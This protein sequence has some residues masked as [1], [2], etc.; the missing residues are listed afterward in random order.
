MN[1][2]NNARS[3]QELVGLIADDPL[4]SSID[5]SYLDELQGQLSWVA[6]AEGET[7]FHEGDAVDGFYFVISGLLE[8][9]KMQED[10]DGNPDNDRLVLAEI[11][12]DSTIGEMQILTGGTRSATVSAA[13][14]SGLVKFPKH[15]F[16][17]FLAKNQNVVDALAKTIMPRLYRDQ[18]VDVLPKL[19]G[20]LDDETLHDL[21]AKMTWRS[22]RRGDVLCYQGEPSESFYVIISGRMQVLIKDASGK[23]RVVTEMSQG[24]SVGEMGVVTGQ[25]RSATIIASRDTELLEFSREEFEEFTQRYP[26]LMRRMTRLLI[27]RLQR[28]SRATRVKNLSANILLAPASEGVE[29]GKFVQ[30]LY[31]ALQTVDAGQ[32]DG[33]LPCLL[34]TSEEVDRRLGL[35]GISQTD[36]HR[37]DDL[38][39]RS[40]LSDQE[41][42]YAVIL[43]QADTTVTNWTS[44]CIRNADE[45]MY[46]ADADREPTTTAVVR[47]VQEQEAK[48][49][50]RRYALILLH[51]NVNRPQGTI[52][53]LEKLKLARDLLSRGGRGRHFHIRRHQ[54]SDYQRLA[55]YVLGRE[56]GLVLSGG[57]ARGF[58]HVGCIRAMHELGI[59]IDM[60]GGVSMG[61][62]V[63]A[64]Y[65]YDPDRFEETIRTVESQLKGALFDITPPVVSFA[66]G[67]RFDKRLRGWFGDETRIEDLWMPYFCVSSNLTEAEI[68]VHESGPLWWSVRASG[69]LP[70]LSSPVVYNKNLLFD[71]CLLDNLPMDVMRERLGSAT[72]IA[73]DVVPPH[74]L[75]VEFPDVQSPSGWWLLWKKLN[76][77]A[78]TIALPNIVA[79]LHRAGELGSV[80][81]RQKLID[82]KIA[83]RYIQPP[84]EHITITD[85][86]GVSEAR[87]I[88][89]DFCKAELQSWWPKYQADKNA[90]AIS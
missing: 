71:G 82:Q 31:D 70:G 84:V 40:W 7:L 13:Q 64:A 28:A 2:P 19:F 53:W 63:S 32:P 20:E 57:G 81:G 52:R 68:V 38:R 11:G 51:D 89:Y 14:P 86:G 49:A 21:E 79:I 62:L 78:K 85:F 41:K 76:P 46:V 1:P 48:H 36:E 12:P 29:L 75:K 17:T 23:S 87:K 59:P 69:T 42:K 34:L 8:V 60:I 80:Y 66:R 39:L 18:M 25:P 83:D 90:G 45:I 37:P 47:E 65:A 58:A 6:L 88:G 43:L 77:F 35:P 22:L 55:R 67:H 73:V 4:L 74:D 56:V 5:R 33:T 16:D 26:E 61:S 44:R 24:E 30:Q 27:T 9:S 50:E 54:A 10:L 3:P 15:A 72:V